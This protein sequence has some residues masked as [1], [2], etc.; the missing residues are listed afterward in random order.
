[1]RR[2][3]GRVYANWENIGVEFRRKR[4]IAKRVIK[5]NKRR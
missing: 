3:R 1:M 2:A 4:N 5:E